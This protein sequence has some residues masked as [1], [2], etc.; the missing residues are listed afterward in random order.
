MAEVGN[1]GKLITFRVSSKKVQTFSEMSR[2]VSGRWAEHETIKGKPKSE[3]LGADLQEISLSIV[4]SANLGVKPRKV[5]ERIAKA[6]ERGEHFP[7]VLN[8]KKV[9]KHDFKITESSES[10]EH[11]FSKGQLIHAKVDLVLREYV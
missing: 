7:F 6:V 1:L 8:G 3:F 11:V 10:W 2:K 4:L 5:L 9:S